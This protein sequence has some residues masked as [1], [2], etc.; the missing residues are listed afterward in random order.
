MVTHYFTLHALSKELDGTLRNAVVR[1]V[2]TQ[3]K[4]EL[5]IV[6]ESNGN[7]RCL[8]ISVEPKLNFIF[9]RDVFARAKKNSVD[10]FQ[11]IVGKTIQKIVLQK[12]ER[13]LNITKIGRAS[14]RERV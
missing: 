7:E 11:S 4:N 5:L 13:A 12:Y 1:E 2:F 9:L 10:L 8:N 6:T 3:Q 14:C